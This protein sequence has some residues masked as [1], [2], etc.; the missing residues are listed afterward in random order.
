MSYQPPLLAPD[1]D[2]VPPSEFPNLESAKEI[3]ID[4][5]TY[6]PELTTRGSGWPRN[7][8]RIVGVAVS[9]DGWD[10]YYPVA[11]ENGGNMDASMVFSWL[12]EELSRPDQPK[13]FANAQYDAGWL[14]A[15]GIAVSGSWFDIQV[16]EPLIDENRR[17]YRLDALAKDYLGERKDEKLLR[18]AAESWGVDPKAGLHIL[19]PN[20]V[21]PY[22]V[23]D[24]RLTLAVWQKQKPILE[25]QSLEPI[26]ELESSLLPLMVAMRM[27]GIRVDQSGAHQL[28]KKWAAEEDDLLNK[29]YHETEK[30][31]DCWAPRSI[32]P[33]LEGRGMVLPRTVTDEPSITSAWLESQKDEVCQMLVRVRKINKARST[34]LDGMILKHAHK[35][36]IHTQFN[37][38]RSDDKGTVS[39]R[40]SASDPNLQQVPARDPVI[41]P[42]IRNLFLPEEGCD[43]ASLDYSQQEPRL[44][45]HYA[46]L[47][48]LPG[49][50]EATLEYQ[51]NPKTD[52]HQMV[53]EMA[54]ISRKQAKTINLGLSYGMG[55]KKLAGELGM[56]IEKARELFAQYHAKVPFVRSLSDQAQKQA[57][58]RGWIRTTL[59]RRCRFDRWTNANKWEPPLP[60]PE[61]Q[62]KWK[63]IERA[64]TYRAM[65]RLIQSSAADMTKAAMADLWAEG[66]VPHLTIHDELI[67][68]VEDK[69]SIS[70]IREVMTT[71]VPDLKVPM[72]VDVEIGP[73]WGKTKETKI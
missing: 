3:C 38:L 66:I 57:E 12:E 8:G 24:S 62:Q 35:G 39:G 52:F 71:C 22:A 10:G 64:F 70:R 17:T 25:H 21:G 45:C 50:E 63:S 33:V 40:F 30:T 46:S 9:V 5:E 28:S 34:F 13:V 54:G 43:L 67:F 58:K 32:A 48:G 51:E 16:A 1:S 14:L 73:T 41:G 36:R 44:I 29:I 7:H 49:A 15:R 68:S 27:R 42:A 53:A 26:F 69:A 4:L 19:P 55:Q 37:A 56:P 65:N 60:L 47:M 11:H 31:V 2:W 59:G 72:Q 20:L 23:A 6:D 61:A 18:E